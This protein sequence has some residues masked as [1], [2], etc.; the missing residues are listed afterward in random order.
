MTGLLAGRLL[1]VAGANMEL[2]QEIIQRDN[3]GLLQR[4]QDGIPMER[5]TSALYVGRP[6]KKKSL[7]TIRVTST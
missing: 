3:I 4:Q 7:R 6:E 2:I 1:E 5:M